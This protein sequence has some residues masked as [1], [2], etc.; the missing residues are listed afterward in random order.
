MALAP[1]EDHPAL[2][3]NPLAASGATV[4]HDCDSPGERR[5]THVPIVTF[6]G[7]VFV[8]EEEG[9]LRFFG[10]RCGLQLQAPFALRNPLGPQTAPY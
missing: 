4:G 7:R 2:E 1:N 8:Y 6:H 10:A 3:T 9:S 5:C